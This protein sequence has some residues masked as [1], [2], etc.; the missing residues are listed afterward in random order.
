MENISCPKRRLCIDYTD[1]TLL[2]MLHGTCAVRCTIAP[3]ARRPTVCHDKRHAEVNHYPHSEAWNLS[4]ERKKSFFLHSPH[5][6]VRCFL[7]NWAASSN[8]S[9]VHTC[10]VLPAVGFPCLLLWVTSSGL[11]RAREACCLFARLLPVSFFLFFWFCFGKRN[12][13]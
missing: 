11:P 6:F 7:C 9:R 4:E 1:Q 5:Q 13:G 12:K 10:N 3:T 8:H 2:T